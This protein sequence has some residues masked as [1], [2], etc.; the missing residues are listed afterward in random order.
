MRPKKQ[1]VCVEWYDAVF[2]RD[3]PCGPVR[4]VSYGF[5]VKSDE[6]LVRVAQSWNTVEGYCE[7]L[8]VPRGMV[9]SITL[10]PALT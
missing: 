7:F 1:V 9:T 3:N 4:T 2:T 8:T 5:L 10:V 6:E